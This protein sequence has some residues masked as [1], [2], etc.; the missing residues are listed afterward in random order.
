MKDRAA[1]KKAFKYANLRIIFKCFVRIFIPLTICQEHGGEGECRRHHQRW[2]ALLLREGCGGGGGK[3]IVFALKKVLLTVSFTN[4][5]Y[6]FQRTV[7]MRMGGRLPA[8]QVQERTQRE[9]YDYANYL[10]FQGVLKIT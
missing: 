6:V 3:R 4:V 8:V 5:F 2:A 7:V 9:W 1:T 10:F